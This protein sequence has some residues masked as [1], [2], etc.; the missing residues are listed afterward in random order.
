MTCPCLEQQTT[1]ADFC[2]FLM[3]FAKFF[4]RHWRLEQLE[5][6]FQYHIC[7]RRRSSRRTSGTLKSG[8]RLTSQNTAM[9][10][11]V[12]DMIDLQPGARGPGHPEKCSE[13]MY[14][15]RRPSQ[16][17]FRRAIKIGVSWGYIDRTVLG[18]GR[19]YTKI[20]NN[21][22][23]KWDGLTR[24]DFPWEF[25]QHFPEIKGHGWNYTIV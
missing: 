18:N 3:P 8:S 17:L 13:S 12:E 11:G 1:N 10:K 7:T 2:W 16:Q 24:I 20:D 6:K 4:C 22:K 14:W 9:H 25:T 21:P 5:N 19:K 15:R 23:S